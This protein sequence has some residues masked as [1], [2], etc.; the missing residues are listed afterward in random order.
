M[1]LMLGSGWGTTYESDVMPISIICELRD[2]YIMCFRRERLAEQGMNGINEILKN[3]ME[4]GV[5]VQLFSKQQIYTIAS[6]K[7]FHYW[8]TI[9]I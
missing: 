6:L 7:I 5:I 4:N 3:I 1:G 9:R 8:D 2:L